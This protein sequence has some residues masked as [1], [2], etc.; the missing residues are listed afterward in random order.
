MI[1]NLTTNDG[2]ILVSRRY[3]MSEPLSKIVDFI[4][5]TSQRY[6]LTKDSRGTLIDD[7]ILDLSPYVFSII[8]DEELES[9]V[10]QIYDKIICTFGFRDKYINPIEGVFT[11][12]L[13]ERIKLCAMNLNIETYNFSNL[14]VITNIEAINTGDICY[15]VSDFLRCLLLA[16]MTLTDTTITAL[17][18]KASKINSRRLRKLAVTTFDSYSYMIDDLHVMSGILEVYKSLFC[19]EETHTALTSYFNS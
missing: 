5:S 17:R 12:D 1:F 9:G 15:T 10:I 2:G 18:G 8:I 6:Y 16:S 3:S 11:S 14:Q 7:K 13:V 19:E 4:H